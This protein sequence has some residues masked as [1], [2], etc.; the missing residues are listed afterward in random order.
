MEPLIVL[1]ACCV[2]LA[3]GALG[4]LALGG[5]EESQSPE[6]NVKIRSRLTRLLRR[7]PKVQTGDT[8]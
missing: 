6:A 4:I 1:G 3:V 5:R 8:R 7:R 2:P